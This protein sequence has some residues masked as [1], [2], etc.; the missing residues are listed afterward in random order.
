MQFL[1]TAVK[2]VLRVLRYVMFGIWAI[3]HGQQL[4]RTVDVNTGSLK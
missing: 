2:H 1:D 4:T 3:N